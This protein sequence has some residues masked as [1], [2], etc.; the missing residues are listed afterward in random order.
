MQRAIGETSVYLHEL[1]NEPTLLELCRRGCGRARHPRT[2][3]RWGWLALARCT[4]VPLLPEK[5]IYIKINFVNPD[6]VHV[7][8]A[9]PAQ[10]CI[11]EMVQLFK[12]SSSHWINHSNPLPCK[13]AWGRG[14]RVGSFSH[15]LCSLSPL[16]G[17]G[18]GVRGR[19]RPCCHRAFP[20][21]HPM[22]RAGGRGRPFSDRSY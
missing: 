14:C 7:L 2:Q 13:L 20:L 15:S 6:H 5:A 17:E 18:A 3:F 9:L 21:S 19:A 10:L 22:G 4:Q 11:E 8:M 16:G 12:G 1:S